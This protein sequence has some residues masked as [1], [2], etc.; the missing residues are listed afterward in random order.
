M[1]LR[2]TMSL[3]L[4]MNNTCPRCRKP[5]KLAVIQQHPTRCDLS[6]HKFECADCGDVKTKIL[7]RKQAVAV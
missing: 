1:E 5:I 4:F 7:F 2:R 6:V 3:D